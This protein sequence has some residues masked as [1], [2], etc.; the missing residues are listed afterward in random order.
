MERLN[1]EYQDIKKLYDYKVKTIQNDET[2]LKLAKNI[3]TNE[4]I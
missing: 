2:Y 1:L 3:L 4:L